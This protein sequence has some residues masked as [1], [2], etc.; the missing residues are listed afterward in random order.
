[1][2]LAIRKLSVRHSRS[3]GSFAQEDT[4]RKANSNLS[5][6]FALR[7]RRLISKL[8]SRSASPEMAFPKEILARAK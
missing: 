6:A 3:T 7:N 1:M 5:A 8:S 4:L 2:L